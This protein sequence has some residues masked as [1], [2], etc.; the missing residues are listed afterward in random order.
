MRRRIQ[1]R[2]YQ[3]TLARV[4][5]GAARTAWLGMWRIGYPRSWLGRWNREFRTGYAI[6]GNGS[7]EEESLNLLLE[8]GFNSILG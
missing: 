1:R 8:S 2:L 7:G 3:R 5:P 6:Y 4:G